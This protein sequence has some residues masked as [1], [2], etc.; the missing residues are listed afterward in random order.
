VVECRPPS[1]KESGVRFNMAMRRVGRVGFRLL[2]GTRCE[3]NG[4]R[5]ESSSG[6]GDRLSSSSWKEA[7]ALGM[8]GTV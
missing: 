1:E 5:E 2:M 7:I 4:V 3:D 8:G 6:K